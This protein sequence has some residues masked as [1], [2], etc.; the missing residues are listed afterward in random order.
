MYNEHNDTHSSQEFFCNHADGDPVSAPKPLVIQLVALQNLSLSS[1]TQDGIP[2]LEGHIETLEFRCVQLVATIVQ[3]VMAEVIGI[4]PTRIHLSLGL[5]VFGKK[6]GCPYAKITVDSLGEG[7]NER[8]QIRNVVQLLPR[9]LVGDSQDR[10]DCWAAFSG[11]Q[12]SQL[13]AFA[14]AQLQS[15][16]GKAIRFP[17]ESRVDDEI[18]NVMT[19]RY[20]PKADRSNFTPVESTFPARFGGQSRKGEVIFFLDERGCEIKVHVGKMNYTAQAIGQYID[21]KALYLVK[22]HETT[23]KAGSKIL[24][25]V[26]FE[27]DVSR[28]DLGE[29][30]I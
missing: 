12:I 4:E 30:T 18:V 11:V 2:V 22:V 7:S 14:Q 13:V 23:S 24:T 10:S 21:S 8:T 27:L 26:G 19:G 29:V 5:F 20:A 9:L 17:I 28:S 16:G 3:S 15:C 6:A 25:L 1:A